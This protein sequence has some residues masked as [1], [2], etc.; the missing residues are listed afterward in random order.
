MNREEFRD[1]AEKERAAD[2]KFKR[3]VM[4]CTAAGCISS[5]AQGV[6]KAFQ[7]SVKEKGLGDVRVMGTADCSPARIITA[8]ERVMSEPDEDFA[9]M[10]EGVVDDPANPLVDI[11]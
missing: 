10:F 11:G 9:A 6:L 1:L 3:R 5:G 7:A 8:E 2:R 4:V